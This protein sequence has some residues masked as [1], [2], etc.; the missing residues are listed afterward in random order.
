MNP[1][2]T[3]PCHPLILSLLLPPIINHTLGFFKLGHDLIHVLISLLLTMTNEGV[4]RFWI[5]PLQLPIN[6]NFTCLKNNSKYQALP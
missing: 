5:A 2:H 1:S 3:N 4:K 6:R